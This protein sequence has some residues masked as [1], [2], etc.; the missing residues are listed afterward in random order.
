M[1]IALIGAGIV[2]V[3]SAYELAADGHEVTVFE[4][5]NAAAAETSFA[6]AGVVA[7]GYITPW[8]VPGMP[9]KLMR[10]IFSSHAPVRLCL[11]LSTTELVWMWKWWRSCNLPTYLANLKRLQRL[12]FYSHERLHHLSA[13]LKLEYERAEGYMVLFRS[14]KDN[15]LVRPG[16]Q[17]L[18]EAGVAFK[19]I[20]AAGARLIEPAL[21]SDAVFHGAIHFPNDEVSNCRQFVLLLKTEAQRLGVNFLFSTTVEPL[22][23]ASPATLWTVNETS[24]PPKAQRFDAVVVCA[25]LHSAALLRP[26]GLK[27][28]LAGVYGYSVSAKI[29]EPLSAPNAALMDER[30]KVVISRIGQRVRV[31]GGAEI[32]G[33]PANQRDSAIKTLYKVLNDWFPGAA[34]LS[35]GVQTWKGARPMLP[36]GCPILGVSGIPRVWLNLGHGSSG[37]ALSCGSARVVADL[38]QRRSPSVDLEGLGLSRLGL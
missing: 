20:D 21:C 30:Y 12:A 9:A 29:R 1:K 6:N 10:H 7:S 26:L 14:Q 17:V 33:H 38:I 34:Q 11:P 18:R 22:D 5:R 27:I 37:W 35:S 23:P 3:T 31:A 32:G 8:A 36:D 16:L 24:E 25:G 2:G 19:E 4:R 13:E 15:L 28:P